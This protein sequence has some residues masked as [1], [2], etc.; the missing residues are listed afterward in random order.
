MWHLLDSLYMLFWR[1]WSPASR[2]YKGLTCSHASNRGLPWNCND[3]WWGDL[4]HPPPHCHYWELI[5]TR[6]SYEK[7]NKCSGPVAS[8]MRDN[9]HLIYCAFKNSGSKRGGLFCWLLKP[10]RLV[11]FILTVLA[12]YANMQLSCQVEVGRHLP[13]PKVQ[14]RLNDAQF[15]TRGQPWL[16]GHDVRWFLW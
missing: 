7:E 2:P 9:S 10:P 15:W 13:P 12:I 8:G 6:F 1:R 11:F 16:E 3:H 4:S 14:L 5:K